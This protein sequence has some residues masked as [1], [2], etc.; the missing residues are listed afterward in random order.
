MQI[1]NFFSKKSSQKD[2]TKPNVKIK[3]SDGERGIQEFQKRTETLKN[4]LNNPNISEKE[5]SKTLRSFVDN[6]SENIIASS[7]EQLAKHHTHLSQQ[8]KN[9]K[10][11]INN[12]FSNDKT[13]KPLTNH[14]KELIQF[15]QN[16]YASQ[17]TDLGLQHSLLILKKTTRD[18]SLD[19]KEIAKQVINN[20]ALT[21]RQTHSTQ[22]DITGPLNRFIPDD[23]PS[24]ATGQI[25]DNRQDKSGTSSGSLFS[26]DGSA[27]V[28][29]NL[30]KYGGKN[31][32]KPIPEETTQEIPD[33]TG[34]ITKR[35]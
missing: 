32:L 13:Q 15:V 35:T 28:Q 33:N 5:K 24:N 9:T 34:G 20:F 22:A 8:H 1:S 3:F 18:T 30:L 27:T 21:N 12:Y 19:F 6:V 31:A 23:G 14:V 11:N 16:N 2:I 29:L 4:Q 25:T 17:N 26:E 10:E 7:I